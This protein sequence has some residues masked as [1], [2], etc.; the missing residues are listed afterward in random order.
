M[1]AAPD[2]PDPLQ[3]RSREWPSTPYSDEARAHE[4]PFDTACNIALLGDCTVDMGFPPAIRPENHLAVRLRRAFP[5]QPF[6]G[7]G[8]HTR[9]PGAGSS[10]SVWG[11]YD[12]HPFTAHCPPARLQ[13]R[14]AV[15][16][17]V[18]PEISMQGARR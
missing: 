12:E 7:V 17:C 3:G 8:R 14:V 2:K 6:G 15:H 10:R 5:G 9:R 4:P 1:E 16:V 11:Q 18:S 13:V